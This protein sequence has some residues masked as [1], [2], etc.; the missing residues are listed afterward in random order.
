MKNHIYKFANKV[1]KQRAGDSIGLRATGVVAQIVVNRWKRR[2]MVKLAQCMVI[3]YMI[4]KYVD[5]VNLVLEKIKEGN[6]WNTNKKCLEWS[7][8]KEAEDQAN[9]GAVSD[10]KR[11]DN[12]MMEIS[13]D[14][15]GDVKLEFTAE[16]SKVGYK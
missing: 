15:S 6:R 2:I 13:N 3:L 1:Y 14:M 8:E 10:A 9:E 16:M 11:T 4:S 5:D 7:K 12:L